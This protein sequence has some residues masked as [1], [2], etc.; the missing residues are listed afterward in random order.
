MDFPRVFNPSFALQSPLPHIVGH[1]VLCRWFDHRSREKWTI[2]HAGLIFSRLNLVPR[3]QWIIAEGGLDCLYLS[4]DHQSSWCVSVCA[5]V[6]WIITTGIDPSPWQPRHSSGHQGSE[7]SVDQCCRS[8][9]RW[10]NRSPICI[11]LSPFPV[12]FGVSAQL[13]RTLGKRNTFIGTPFW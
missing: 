13:D 6:Y 5:R 2:I 3:Y 7:R 12:D 9:I 10:D 11:I 1:G 8:E 4:G